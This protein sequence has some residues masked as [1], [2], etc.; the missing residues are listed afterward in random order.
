MFATSL[1]LEVQ[2]D[3]TADDKG[4]IIIT[5]PA[6]GSGNIVAP[7]LVPF[8]VG[9]HGGG[10]ENG[11]KNSY[12]WCW[13]RLELL[14][15]GVAFVQLS[16]RKASQSPFPGPFDDCVARLR[17][18]RQHGARFGL[19]AE[20]CALFGCSSGGHLVS[21]LSTRGTCGADA[22]LPTIRAFVS[23]AGVMDLASLYGAVE[24][25]RPALLS[26][27]DDLA[28]PNGASMVGDPAAC[29][30]ACESPP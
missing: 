11:D 7:Q 14:L 16:H 15:P 1:R 8:V 22:T 13:R 26:L 6:R 5:T 30:H 27:M 10:W 12:D 2:T 29:A 20:Q 23:F 4:V 18:L 19:D 3:A 9:I 24:P 28:P 25:I 17:W 21:L